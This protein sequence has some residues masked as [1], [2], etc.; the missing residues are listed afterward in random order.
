VS[1]DA[2]HRYVV[3]YDVA[4]DGRRTRIATRLSTFGDRLQYSVFVIDGRPAKLV[5]LRLELAR[6]IDSQLDSV[7]ICDLGPATSD[8]GARFQWIGRRR[9]ITDATTLVL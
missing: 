3:A 1:R 4:D 5:R 7:L 8:D 2:A 6:L 9:P